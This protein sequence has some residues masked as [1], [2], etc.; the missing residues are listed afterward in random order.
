MQGRS[1]RAGLD[2]DELGGE[3]EARLREGENLAGHSPRRVS[4]GPRG[5]IDLAAHFGGESDLK[6]AYAYAEFD[7]KDGGAA[8]LW[9]GSD[10][11]AKVWWNGSLVHEVCVEGRELMP[12]Q[13][14]IPVRLEPGTNRVLAKIENGSGA[15]GFAASV[16]DEDGVAKL[17][18]HELR[19]SVS[20]L[21]I[22]PVA[23]GSYLLGEAFPTLEWRTASSMQLCDAPLEV[24]WSGPDGRP[25][26][27]PSLGGR[28]LAHVSAR[29]LDGSIHQRTLAFYRSLEPEPIAP[30][31]PYLPYPRLEVPPIPWLR[32]APET[33]QDPHGDLSDA[34]WSGLFAQN[35]SRENGAILQAALGQPSDE[36]GR[37]GSS[38]LRD[39]EFKLAHRF[40]NESVRG[41]RLA[42]PTRS[43]TPATVL[44]PGDE[45]Q[46]GV[47]R[48]AAER[49][50]QVCRD[51]LAEDP[52]P[53]A[54]LVAR[55]GRVFLHEGFGAPA[56]MGF[57][58]ASI[59]KSI[60]GL[61]FAQFLDQERADLDQSL[62]EVLPNFPTSGKANVT[63]RNCFSHLSGLS[64]HMSLGGLLNPW[65]DQ[66]LLHDHLPWL[67]PGTAHLYNGDGYNLA[68]K[69]MERLAGVSLFRLLHD[70]MQKPFEEDVVQMDLGFGS[71]FTVRYLGKVGQMLLNRGSY[72]DLR[73]FGEPTYEKLLPVSLSKF[74]SRLHNND[75]TWG[76][77]LTPMLDGATNEASEG[78]LG[79]NVLGHGSASMSVWR[80]A[81]DQEVVVA[82]GR[83]GF[84]DGA[85]TTAYTNRFM[86]TLAEELA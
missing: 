61:L 72:G 86:Q 14:R 40:E 4:A 70:F 22:G 33:A 83:S 19:R 8:E 46:A 17:A 43:E 11:G 45:A 84:R 80:V 34:L 27:A 41:R 32:L 38:F 49:L 44:Q 71:R 82:I 13:D 39:Y 31:P 65:L 35:R 24:R 55:R 9:F 52:E 30:P 10:D 78:P 74:E 5:A 50:R 1:P 56:D 6:M 54:V 12:G 69:A 29:L 18:A 64:G 73:F 63:W 42:A 58:P 81:P 37:L 59:G 51:W 48:G 28:Y 85:L 68:G 36:P 2:R 20:Q 67:E 25:S 53:F 3:A 76:V 47:R 21:E 79:P 16:F 66:D 77:G 15:W 62:G 26:E 60:A 57:Y 23:G 7:S 75:M